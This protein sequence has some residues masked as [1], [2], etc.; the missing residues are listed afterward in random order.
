MIKSSDYC[1]IRMYIISCTD[2]ARDV[3]KILDNGLYFLQVVVEI[4]EKIYHKV[5]YLKIFVL[6][7]YLNTLNIAR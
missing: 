7:Q 6:I 3:P 4:T 2:M 1:E 5:W